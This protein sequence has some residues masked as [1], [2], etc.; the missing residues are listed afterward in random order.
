MFLL[1][2]VPSRSW[3]ALTLNGTSSAGGLGRTFGPG[4]QDNV[5]KNGGAKYFLSVD[6]D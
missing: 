4:L 2:I 3:G 6:M 5:A 1:G